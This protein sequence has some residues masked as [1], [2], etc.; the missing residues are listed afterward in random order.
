MQIDS[1]PKTGYLRIAQIFPSIIPVCESTG[2]RWIKK[3]SFP[4]PVKLSRCVS[5][6]KVEEV[7]EWL[8]QRDAAAGKVVH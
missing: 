6:F 1:L 3:G 4:S 7:R 5:A 2:W 8:A